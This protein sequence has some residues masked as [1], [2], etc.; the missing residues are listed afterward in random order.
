[1]RGD[2]QGKDSEENYP[3]FF[4]TFD[5][6]MHAQWMQTSDG[7]REAKRRIEKCTEMQQASSWTN[8]GTLK[9]EKTRGMA[10]RV[11]T[12]CR[13]SK[14]DEKAS[15]GPGPCISTGIL[16]SDLSGNSEM[17]QLEPGMGPV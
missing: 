16:S 5:S 15:K 6:L 4:P 9:E 14:Q 7:A 1:M 11:R 17:T 3:F 2:R 13:T 10:N 12:E 8:C